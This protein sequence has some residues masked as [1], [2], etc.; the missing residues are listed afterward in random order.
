MA[1]VKGK[2]GNPGGRPK[3]LVNVV[4]LA[5]DRTAKNLA[6]LAYWADQREDGGIAVRASIALHEIAW[7]KPVQQNEVSGTLNVSM[8]TVLRKI[9]KDARKP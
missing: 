3:A 8:N 9:R 2:S 6:N 7:G 5:R 4:E 1:F